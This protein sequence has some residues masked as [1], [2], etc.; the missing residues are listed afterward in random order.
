MHDGRF[1]WF[2]TA[3]VAFIYRL[4]VLGWT[5]LDYAGLDWTTRKRTVA[6]PVCLLVFAG[7]EGR[8]RLYIKYGRICIACVYIYPYMLWALIAT[9]GLG[10]R[11]ELL[12]NAHVVAVYISLMMS[13]P[14]TSQ[15]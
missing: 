8:K 4:P 5:G 3:C 9:A 7:W 11:D 14:S 13:S 2:Q 12:V 10:F 6:L 15:I 1:L